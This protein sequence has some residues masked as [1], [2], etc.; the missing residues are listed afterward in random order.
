MKET[1]SYA[2]GKI[3]H[4]IS[5]YSFFC[6]FALGARSLSF[7]RLRL[8]TSFPSWFTLPSPQLLLVWS[9]TT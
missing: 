5:H 7:D 3:V 6:L 4:S 8:P 9:V 1:D 2:K